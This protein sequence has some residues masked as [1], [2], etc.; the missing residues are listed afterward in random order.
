MKPKI[1]GLQPI[2]FVCPKCKS[3]VL[4][5]VEELWE[6]SSILGVQSEAALLGI[7]T[8][9]DYTYL[10]RGDV[11]DSDVTAT[12]QYECA[13]CQFVVGNTEE[14]TIEWLKKHKMLGEERQENG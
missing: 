4:V 6:T 3:K 14:E 8:E 13:N 5:V 1:A 10:R 9:N 7:Q 2:N 12:L 11:I